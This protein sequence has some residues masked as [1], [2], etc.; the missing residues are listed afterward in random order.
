MV[1]HGDEM[2]LDNQL[3]S[4]LDDAPCGIVDLD[5]NLSITYCNAQFA[6]LLG[7]PRPQSLIGAAFDPLLTP[8]TRLA[9]HLHVMPQLQLV[10]HAEEIFVEFVDSDGN[11]APALVY[12]RRRM[13]N[14]A[15]T[16]RCAIAPIRQRQEVE[17]ELLHARRAANQAPGGVYQMLVRQDGTSCFPYTSAGFGRLFGLSNAVLRSDA[18][19]M[20][21]RLH[22]D[23]RQLIFAKFAQ[24]GSFDGDEQVEF[25][26]EN[27][28]GE[29]R[30]FEFR[31][32]PESLPNGD[33][34]W[35]GYTQD[36]TERKQ[37]E[38]MMQSELELS[39]FT[40]AA[41]GDAVI[42]V[43][44]DGRVESMNPSAEKLT[45]WRLTEAKARPIEEV[46]VLVRGHD[47]A[48]IA[49]PT[50]ASIAQRAIVALDS[51]SRLR[52][53]GAG[54][55]TVDVS[56][57][58]VRDLQGTVTAA[59]L[60]L[61]DVSF[62]EQLSDEMAFRSNRDP[63]TGLVNRA[64][65]ER[66][67]DELIRDGFRD[68]QQHAFC[69]I[70][71][72]QFKIV[73]ETL[74]YAA[75]DRLLGDVAELLRRSTGA[76]HTVARLSG[77]RFAVLLRDTHERDADAAVD[78]LSHALSEYRF[79]QDGQRLRVTASIGVAMVGHWATPPK[80]IK[81]AESACFTAKSAGHG[82]TYR[83]VAAD[84]EVQA[85]QQQMEW[86]TKLAE[87]IEDNHL[88]LYAQPIRTL[89]RR[90]DAL[91]F[92]VL[93]RLVDPETDEVVAPGLFMPAAEQYGLAPEVDRWVVNA[94]FA[95]MESQPA[96]VLSRLGTMAINLSGVSVGNPQ[97]GKF[98]TDVLDRSPHLSAKVCFEITETAAV[99]SLDQAVAV[100]QQ[101]QA[102]GATVALDDFGVG[103]SSMAYLKRLPVD[104]V[105]IDGQFVRDMAT[106]PLDLAMVRSINDI[107]HLMDKQTI[108]E[109]VETESVLVL[110][111][112][113]GVDHA[114]GYFIGRPMPIDDLIASS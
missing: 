50:R 38:S 4:S 26:A 56:A 60:V 100:I 11:P 99:G 52:T 57:A 66:E 83:F 64:E 69:L 114:Q 81:A 88:T 54:E 78:T 2:L 53:R 31:S 51:V 97:F 106:D 92:E 48:H 37:L 27:G 22:P 41:I 70:D 17:R 113:L 7:R 16:Y 47:D 75:G 43:D 76:C 63:L 104:F 30:W 95:W 49:D 59:V 3:P 77:D 8:A 110:L 107:A 72:D 108:A 25:R 29:M 55:V 35:F 67:L 73:N 19:T 14:D 13:I 93:L 96:E 94:A 34:L 105:K 32:R 87:A 28:S 82:H 91:H 15:V 103:M 89:G 86:A 20:L 18:R 68:A 80:V 71:L 40:L 33:T 101:L 112:S 9:M 98:L 74:G 65:I 61:Q 21:R 24:F 90:D 46:V 36:I 45:G 102:R 23:D 1:M 84:V 58:P 79:E 12:A 6:M 62:R 109:F 44:A 85:Q 39:R 10:G 42:T 5:E 111:R